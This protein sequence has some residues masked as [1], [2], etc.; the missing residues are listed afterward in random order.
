M[1]GMSR[2]ARLLA[3]L[4]LLGAPL[5]VIGP[6]AAEP[7]GRLADQVTDPVGVLGDAGDVQDALDLLREE[8]GV[9]LFVA[10]V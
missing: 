8:E 3:V 2:L 10:F 4:L 1:C 9:Q 6:A 7:P 5:L